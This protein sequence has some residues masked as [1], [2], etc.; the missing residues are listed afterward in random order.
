MNTWLLFFQY[1]TCFGVELTMNNAAALYF[2]DK[3]G[4]ST[5]S[6]GAIASLCGW[7]NLF[8]RG[9]GGYISDKMNAKLALR[10]RI[11]AQ[12]CLLVGEGVMVLIFAETKSLEGA[13]VA[14]IFFS[15]FAQSAS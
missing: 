2:K 15:I 9:L 10:G 12:T 8:A 1:A 5:E 6:A 11:L 3:F 13:I 7:M 14:M 4:Q